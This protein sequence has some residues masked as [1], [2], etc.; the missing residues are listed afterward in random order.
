MQKKIF[1]SYKELEGISQKNKNKVHEI[2][3]LVREEIINLNIINNKEMNFENI[4]VL[5]L[6]GSQKLLKF[7]QIYSQK[8]LIKLKTQATQ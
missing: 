3:N 7:L 1:V 8:F 4:K 2:G 6:G 5:V